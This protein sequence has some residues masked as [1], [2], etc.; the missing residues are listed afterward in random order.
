PVR[1]SPGQLPGT[2]QV[3][4]V[5]LIRLDGSV[6]SFQAKVLFNGCQFCIETAP[7]C[8]QLPRA[9][10]LVFAP[11]PA[12]VRSR[13][14]GA[15]HSAVI[16]PASTT[17]FQR[18]VSPT[19]NSVNWVPLLAT[20]SKPM[21]LNCFLTSGELTAAAISDSSLARTSAGKPLGAAAA[22]QE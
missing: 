3:L 8:Q 21:S 7:C 19:R 16:F 5:A 9:A 17:F 15:C 18:C 14:S 22:C 10:P 11:P 6:L 20:T 2:L 1:A 13:Q 12:C 4:M